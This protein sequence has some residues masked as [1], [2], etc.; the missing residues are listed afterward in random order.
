[1]R[2]HVTGI[3]HAKGSH[4]ALDVDA[5]SKAAAEKRAQQAGMDVQH[6][7]PIGEQQSQGR[8]TH[9]GEFETSGAGWIFKVI[10]VVAVVGAIAFVVWNK[11][12][13]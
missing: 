2:F 3:D 11:L 13:R 1:M 4:M 6:I 10:I 5:P 9:R 7:H 8:A 12:Q